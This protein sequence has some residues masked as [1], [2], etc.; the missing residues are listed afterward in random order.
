[1]RVT[2]SHRESKRPL[3]FFH[4]YILSS[5]TTALSTLCQGRL[6]PHIYIY[7]Y[8]YIYIHENKM[9]FGVLVFSPQFFFRSLRFWLCVYK[10]KPLNSLSKVVSLLRKS[11]LKLV[12]IRSITNIH[13]TKSAG[14]KI[15]KT[16]E[17]WRNTSKV[18]FVWCTSSLV[19]KFTTSCKVF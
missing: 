16:I 4:F 13:V 5:A 18:K 17:P 19:W 7:I 11:A 9:I 1:M 2:Q 14:V 12:V 6:Y 10:W 3:W 15:V 8:I